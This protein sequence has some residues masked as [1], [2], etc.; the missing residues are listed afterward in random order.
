MIKIP[1]CGI[2][3][4][5]CTPR[6]LRDALAEAK[7]AGESVELE[8]SSPGGFIAPGLEM[9]NLIRNFDGEANVRITGYAMSMASYI[10]LAVKAKKNPGIIRAE[11]NAVFMIHNA[12]GG[13]WGDHNDVLKYGGYLKGLSGVI[14]KQYEK[15]TGKP[16]SEIIAMMDKETF[17]FGDEMIE[18]GFVDEIIDT[19]SGDDAEDRATAIAGARAAFEDAMGKLSEKQEEARADWQRAA[20]LLESAS[21]QPPAVAE[22]PKQ[23]VQQMVTLQKLLAENPEAK[24]EF[25]KA[26]ADAT[27]AGKSAAEAAAK[28]SIDKISPFLTSKDY[29]PVIGETALKVLKGEESMVTLTASVAAVDAV[30]QQAATAA[31]AAE[32]AAAADTPGQ[33]QDDVRE[34]GATVENEGDLQAEIARMKEGN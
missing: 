22:N 17:F 7:A 14:A 21:N 33:H 26:I 16:M 31:A 3:G 11:D 27:E 2:I 18:H 5:D 29:P 24:A 32:T 6:G 15:R 4:W 30:K 28:A 8:V 34:P 9:F 13:A 12:R 25:D 1:I 20:A 19:E 10:P 23:E